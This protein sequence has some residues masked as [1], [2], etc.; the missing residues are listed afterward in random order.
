M[1][2]RTQQPGEEIDGNLLESERLVN[3]SGSTKQSAM[4]KVNLWRGRCVRL[5]EKR[6][7]DG[8]YVRIH[9]GET[10]PDSSSGK[11]KDGTPVAALDRMTDSIAFSAVE[12]ESV[13]RIGD[14][15]LTIHV[16]HENAFTRQ[17]NLVAI[18]MLLVPLLANVARTFVIEYAN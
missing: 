8:K 3:T 9:V 5:C 2:Y 6:R 10:I 13:V 12:E 16:P 7:L 14:N 4:Q 15:R 11:C 1:S 18:H 17:D